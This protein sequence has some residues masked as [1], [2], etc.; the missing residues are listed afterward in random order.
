MRAIAPHDGI[1]EDELLRARW[2]NLINPGRRRDIW[3][4]NI[5][6]R[7]ATSE[8]LDMFAIQHHMSSTQGEDFHDIH[9]AAALFFLDNHQCDQPQTRVW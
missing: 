8:R 1:W 3:P 9:S 6:S 2:G 7:N 4:V 5:A